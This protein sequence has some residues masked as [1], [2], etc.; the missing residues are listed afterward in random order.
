MKGVKKCFGLSLVLSIIFGL[1]LFGFSEKSN[2]TQVNSGSGTYGYIISGNSTYSALWSGSI[3]RELITGASGISKSLMGV[4]MDFYIPSGS[5][6][7]SYASNIAQFY[8]RIYQQFSYEKSINSDVEA[9]VSGVSSRGDALT[10]SCHINDSDNNST[11]WVC[12]LSCSNYDYPVSASMTI[13]RT[14][15]FDL[16]T[17]PLAYAIGV[18]PSNGNSIYMQYAAYEL[19]SY[20]DPNTALIQQQI[21]Q[22]QT[23]INQNDRTNELLEEQ[24]KREQ[25]DRDNLEQQ[26]QDGKDSA[27]DSQADAENTGTTLLQAFTAFVDALTSA[28]PSNCNLDMDLGNLDMGVVNLCSLSP[29]A[30]FS[31]LASIFLILFCVPLSIATARKVIT[32]F[33]SFQS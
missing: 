22:N 4:Q 9:V 11:E 32:L 18:P 3:P 17:T 27:D 21:N 1:S 29:P 26:A 31:A 13:G 30:G 15:T 8:M 2:A 23:I 7:G 28:T 24:A 19:A 16:S 25:Q 6:S 12:T 10:G 20:A 33:R 14:G 5:F